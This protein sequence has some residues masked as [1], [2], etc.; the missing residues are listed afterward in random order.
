MSSDVHSKDHPTRG[1]L[2]FAASLSL[3][4]V[5]DAIAKLLSTR[6]PVVEIV[7]AR[8]VVYAVAIVP[9]TLWQLGLAGLRPRHPWWQLARGGCMCLASGCF[10]LA[11]SRM[12]VADAMAIFL[13]YPVVLLPLSA[14][15]L[16]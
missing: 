5:M 14:L 3:L 8:H 13:A 11:V 12:P 10:F 16:G 7:W 4:P 1:Y 6:L 15:L 9:L 2:I